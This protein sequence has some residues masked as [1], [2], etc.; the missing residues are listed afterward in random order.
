M[1]GRDSIQPTYDMRKTGCRFSV[2]TAVAG[3]ALP[4]VE[5]PDPFMYHRV[6][7][8]WRDLL[9]GLFRRH[10]EVIVTVTADPDMVE[11]VLELNADYLGITRST[12]RQEWNAHLECS[13]SDFA[14]QIP[15]HED[16][17]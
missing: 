17:P 12:R 8:G 3:R 7:V 11:D 14:A 1:T 15:E 13:L 2:G 9:R 16:A 4:T 5:M 6:T 10:L